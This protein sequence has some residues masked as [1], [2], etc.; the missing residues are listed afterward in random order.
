VPAQTE[1]YLDRSQGTGTP[2]PDEARRYFEA[3]FSTDF[4][5]VRVHDDDAA[6]Q[7]ARSIGALAFTR[8]RDI[9]FSAGAYDPVTDG[10]RRL[11]AHEL[12]HIAQQNSGIG[13]VD[14][15]PGQADAGPALF[16]RPGVTQPARRQEGGETAAQISAR[17]GM[18]VQRYEAFEHAT[19]GDHAVG[20]MTVTIGGNKLTS[21]EINA[22]ADLYG[23]PEALWSADPVELAN[24]LALIRRQVAGEDIPE[25][26]W[27]K[28]S[29]GRYTKLNLRNAP[30][31]APRNVD[32]IKPPDGTVAATNN[33]DQFERYYSETIVNAQRAF[34]QI[35][36]FD[37]EYKQHWLDRAAVSAGFAEHFLMDAFS[38]GHLFNKDDFIAVLQA[39]LD[40]LDDKKLSDMFGSIAK[41]VLAD[42]GSNTLLAQ[43][44]P[45][46]AVGFNYGSLGYISIWRPN[47][48][49]EFAFK[50]LLEKLYKDPDGRQAVYSALVKV[51][52]DQLSKHDAGGGKV[53]V[54]VENDISTTP[55]I[56]SGDKTLKTSPETRDMIDRAIVQFR[57]LMQPYRTG[58]V[59]GG[60]FAPG[61]E[62]VLAYFPRPTKGS[63][64]LI[65]GLIVEAT[66]PA[67]GTATDLV[68]I[69][70]EQLPSI[71]QNL[72]DRRKIKKA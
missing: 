15:R 9:W 27:D 5:A 16:T 62:K 2:L 53:G 41:Q 17:P 21:G 29:G 54:E 37:P 43:Y 44:E 3:R 68:Q 8:G 26:A 58:P 7:A 25:S 70:K 23:S 60:G 38:A 33:R 66:D 47:L 39:N 46:E 36:L 45:V 49:W 18:A 28:A 71:L 24:L 12:T 64:V 72:E 11:L 55:W 52:H 32:I 19:Q 31:F 42:P 13:R 48:D 20:S 40:A 50:G 30:H 59:E 63:V 67:K 57:A 35:G 61:V 14:H 6:G 69:L 65:K 4:R 10:G 34:H 22:L 51:V 1:R 56:L